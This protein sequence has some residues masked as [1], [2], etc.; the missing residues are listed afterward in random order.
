MLL[1]LLPPLFVVVAAGVVA[2]AAFLSDGAAAAGMHDAATDA[3]PSAEFLFAADA[4]V[5]KEQEHAVVKGHKV[6]KQLPFTQLEHSRPR[7]AF[8]ASTVVGCKT[9]EVWVKLRH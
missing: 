3:G 8:L 5:D 1:L 2:G 4:D 9:S 7:F 6:L